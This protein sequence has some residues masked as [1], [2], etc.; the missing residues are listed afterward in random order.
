[1]AQQGGDSEEQTQK[2]S[3]QAGKKVLDHLANERTFLAWLRTGL[4]MITFGFVIERFGLLLRKLGAR[5]LAPIPFQLYYSAIIG[6]ALT[7]LGIVIMLIALF[8]FLR[9]SRAIDQ[10]TFRPSFGFIIIL[11]VFACCIG[12]L[13]VFYLLL[14]E[15]A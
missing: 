9:V 6:V 11:T 8:D 5:D 13:L 3:D 12:L 4:A 10:E 14:S 15:P 7:L 2:Q 1:M